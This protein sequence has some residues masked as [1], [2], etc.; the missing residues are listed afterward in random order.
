MKRVIIP[1]YVKIL[2]PTPVPGSMQD[3]SSLHQLQRQ[4]QLL[5]IAPHGLDVNVKTDILAV[6][7]EHLSGS[8]CRNKQTRL[9]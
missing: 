8:C 2:H 6:P 7:L 1:L 4:K 3:A 5:A 9:P